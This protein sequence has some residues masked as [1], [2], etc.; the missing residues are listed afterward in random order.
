MFFIT[1]TTN[2]LPNLKRNHLEMFKSG[3]GGT[4]ASWEQ[5]FANDFIFVANDDSFLLDDLFVS[6][7]QNQ[8]APLFVVAR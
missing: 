2:E 5:K 6:L 7:R 1:Q 8:N 3:R 4:P